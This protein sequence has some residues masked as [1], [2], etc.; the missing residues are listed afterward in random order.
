VEGA[1]FLQLA[2]IGSPLEMPAAAS[3]RNGVTV[4]S[5]G[6]EMDDSALKH[7]V[8]TLAQLFVMTHSPQGV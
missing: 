6:C 7:V 1:R 8:L 5:N 2:V 3:A 4:V